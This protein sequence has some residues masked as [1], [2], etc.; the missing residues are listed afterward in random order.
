MTEA[1]RVN[2]IEVR[3]RRTRVHACQASRAPSWAGVLAGLAATRGAERRQTA[4]VLRNAR[5]STGNPRLTARL[6]GTG[7]KDGHAGRTYTRTE[8]IRYIFL[9]ALRQHLMS[10]LRSSPL[11]DLAL[12]SVLHFFIFSCWVIGMAA[13]PSKHCD[14][15]T[16]RSS[17]FLS[18]AWELHALMRSCCG[19]TSFSS[20][21]EVGDQAPAASHTATATASTVFMDAP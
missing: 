6:R 12:A 1:V 21:A 16:F 7:R 19:F 4:T 20:A 9:S 3:G 2:S 13:P 5:R 8:G 14:M 17:P 18:P 10:A 11:S 15:N